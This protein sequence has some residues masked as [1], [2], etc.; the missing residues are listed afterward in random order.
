MNDYEGRLRVTDAQSKREKA[1]YIYKNY[2][3]KS[4][5]EIKFKK[6]SHTHTH[7]L[8]SV[9]GLSASTLDTRAWQH[10]WTCQH[11]LSAPI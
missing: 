9:I 7:T 2:R 6:S 5:T 11:Y 3:K 4:Q 8:S 1:K 10:I